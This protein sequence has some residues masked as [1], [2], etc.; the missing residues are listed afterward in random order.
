MAK[1]DIVPSVTFTVTMT[2]TET[3]ARALA[4][5]SSYGTE[6]VAGWIIPHIAESRA[7]ATHDGIVSLLSD[8]NSK[9]NV[10]LSTV[11]DARK[12]INNVRRS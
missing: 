1:F 11:D 2:L 7:S 6:Q 8:A 9:L 10:I 12:I 3:E 4:N 5:I